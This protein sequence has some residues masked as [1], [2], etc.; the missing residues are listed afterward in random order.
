M[1]FAPRITPESAS[2][3]TRALAAATMQ[4]DLALREAEGPV[5]ELGETIRR[6]AMFLR[7][8]RL[9][10]DTPGAGKPDP[11]LEQ[12]RI[13]LNAGI[14]KLQFYDR[15]VQHLSHVRDYLSGIANRLAE[16][17]A[18]TGGRDPVFDHEAW[19]SLRDKLR[20]RLISEAQRQLLDL[21]LPPPDSK[22]ETQA[23]KTDERPAHGSIELF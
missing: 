14:E 20:T 11:R 8:L 17:S 16:G 23:A 7:D 18:T 4:I 12:L 9:A 2:A 3:C 5:E 10:E 21:M 6:L 15:M 13:E 19:E 22:P 1:S